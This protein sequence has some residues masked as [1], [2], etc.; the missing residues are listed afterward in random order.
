[1]VVSEIVAGSE[2]LF[3]AALDNLLEKLSSGI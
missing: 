2:L 1:L 3:D